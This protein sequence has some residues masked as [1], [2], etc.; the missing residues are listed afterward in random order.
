MKQV[1][2]EL[3]QKQVEF[4]NSREREVHLE[5]G[6]GCGKSSV[7]SL[8]IAKTIIEQKIRGAKWL[9][10]S[11]DYSQLI[12]TLIPLTSSRLTTFGLKE[13]R[14]FFFVKS[15]Y[16]H[17]RTRRYGT[18]D[19]ASSHSYDSAFRSGN[20]SGI[21]GDEV[22][23]WK[24]DAWL[25]FKGRNRVYPEIQRSCSTPFGYNH[26][27]N[28]FHLHK[29]KYRHLINMKTEENFRLSLAY[30]KSLRESYSAKWAMQ[31]LDA[32]RINFAGEP[33]YEAFDRLFNTD[34]G[35]ETLKHLTKEIYLVV[36]YNISN[37]CGVYCLY[38]DG[39]LYI[40]GEEKLKY[41]GSEVMAKKAQTKFP[42]HKILVLGDST[43][44]NQKTTAVDKTNYQIF[45]KNG[46][47]PI[48]FKNPPVHARIISFNS[49]MAAGRVMIDQK[50]TNLINDLELVTWKEGEINKDDLN[51]S[52]A[53][54]AASYA[55]YYF[56][57]IGKRIQ[58]QIR[59]RRY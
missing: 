54:D 35:L 2:I 10:A 53:S 44:N 18:I 46:L 42:Q 3:F 45:K 37:Y 34:Y 30:I 50:C 32:Y 5:G 12:K 1:E 13:E 40:I 16:P 19:F 7:L 52:H 29:S 8:D 43:G 56:Q 24:K 6:L 22:D 15:P 38:M 20:Y 48:K 28:D 47:H 55:D 51:L 41:Q 17:I 59:T 11:L 9:M 27:Y 36:D 14:D 4:I 23:F 26:I 31:E 25:A 57:G 49:N 21:W 33:V 39:I 58:R